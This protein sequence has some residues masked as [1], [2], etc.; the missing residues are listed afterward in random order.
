[1]ISMPI[2]CWKYFATSITQPCVHYIY[3]KIKSIS[4]YVVQLL[5]MFLCKCGNL[6]C[7]LGI[8]NFSRLHKVAQE[9][10]HAPDKC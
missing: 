8:Q 4:A 6:K 3:F 2:K 5:S 10:G 9:H 1:M 7:D